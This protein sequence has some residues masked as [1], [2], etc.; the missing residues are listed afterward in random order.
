MYGD[1]ARL[2]WELWNCGLSHLVV[3]TGLN[4]LKSS[5]QTVSA[6][7]RAITGRN[8]RDYIPS[9]YQNEDCAEVL[10]PLC[11]LGRLPIWRRTVLDLNWARLRA[12]HVR[13]G[14]RV[15][16]W[17][18]SPSPWQQ[19]ARPRFRHVWMWLKICYTRSGKRFDTVD[20]IMQR[21]KFFRNNFCKIFF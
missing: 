1:H 16:E 21:K 13:A 7:H 14:T 9:N 6:S 19:M 12:R 15:K 17:L 8:P 11:L 20:L 4:L 5:I 3:K 18:F 10:A 2:Y